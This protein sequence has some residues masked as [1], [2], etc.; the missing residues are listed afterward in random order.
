[1]RCGG[2]SATTHQPFVGDV[3]DSKVGGGRGAESDGGG[4]AWGYSTSWLCASCEGDGIQKLAG[5]VPMYVFLRLIKRTAC[6]AGAGRIRGGAGRGGG[7]AEVVSAE[8]RWCRG[9]AGGAVRGK[10]ATL[11]GDAVRL[12]GDEVATLCGDAVRAGLRRC[13]ATLCAG[14]GKIGKKGEVPSRLGDLR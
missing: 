8:G 10:V 9:G 13:A 4:C 7:G 1:V 6:G 14:V 5:F 12:C 11:C 2:I 3:V